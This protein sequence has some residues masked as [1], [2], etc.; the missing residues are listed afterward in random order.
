MVLVLSQPSAVD[1]RDAIKN[2]WMKKFR[3][4]QDDVLVRFSIGTKGLSKKLLTDLTS[5]QNN[6]GDLLL[7]QNLTDSYSKLTR[8][9]LMSFVESN[10]CS[11][12]AYLLKCDDDTFPVLEIITAELQQRSS[13]QS[14]YL[15]HMFNRAKVITTGKF[16]ENKWFFSEKYLPYASGSAYILSSDLVRRISLNSDALTLY[17]N[18]DASIGTW[19][20][21]YNIERRNDKRFCAFHPGCDCFPSCVSTTDVFN[22]EKV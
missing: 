21:P 12:F 7:L 2:T 9:V 20:S 1:R 17:H 8:K 14:Y 6:Y 11:N 16:A 5:E 15:G 18:E 10:K 4:K 22:P 13:K 19:I 3:E